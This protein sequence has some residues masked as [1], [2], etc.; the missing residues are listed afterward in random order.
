MALMTKTRQLIGLMLFSAVLPQT[1]AA[2]TLDSVQ[3]QAR[4][5]LSEQAPAFLSL[6]G[7]I[8][9]AVLPSEGN[10][11]VGFGMPLTFATFAPASPSSFALSEIWTA[12]GVLL[13]QPLNIFGAGGLMKITSLRWDLSSN[14]IYGDVVGGNGVGTLTDVALW[15]GVGAISGTNDIPDSLLYLSPS[16]PP[17]SDY[18]L[19]LRSGPLDWTVQGRSLV[20]SSLGLNSSGESLLDTAGD[21]GQ[22][23]VTISTPVPE[24]ST[25]ALS[26]L[27][28]T[29][30]GA[31]VRA[32][33]KAEGAP[34]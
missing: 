25:W 29:L 32:K 7:T 3:T 24:P 28:L 8:P 14:T 4:L 20:V 6:A 31:C 11:S 26:L 10:L 27:G 17:P 2:Q 21:W 15:E 13:T 19:T 16:T 22:F 34:A 9:T 33:R 12:G 30:A 5:E 18:S 23:S 1:V